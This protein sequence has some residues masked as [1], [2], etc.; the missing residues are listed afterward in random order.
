MVFDV[1]NKAVV[2]ILPA[3][4]NNSND[5]NDE[6][7]YFQF[8]FSDLNNLY[9]DLH[10]GIRHIYPNL[11]I[12]AITWY[13]TSTRRHYP[14]FDEQSMQYAIMHCRPL[15]IYVYKQNVMLK[16]RQSTMMF[17]AREN[18]SNQSPQIN[19][20]DVSMLNQMK[21]FSLQFSPVNQPPQQ[22]HQLPPLPI[23]STF[24]NPNNTRTVSWSEN[25]KSEYPMQIEKTNPRDTDKLSSPL[26][27]YHRISYQMPANVEGNYG[28]VHI[29]EPNRFNSSLN[30]LPFSNNQT[31][32]HFGSKCD[33]CQKAI[34]GIR[35]KCKEC[36][37]YDL[38]EKCKGDGRHSYHQMISIPPP[39]SQGNLYPLT[40]AKQ[41]VS[42]DELPQ[43]QSKNVYK[44]NQTFTPD[45]SVEP[46]SESQKK[47]GWHALRKHT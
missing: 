1:P 34:Y 16:N 28:E 39:N 22:R 10:V 25:S 43:G 42:N 4:S 30:E 11:P 46:V 17:T 36:E 44:A 7:K 41:W 23:S 21:Q 13:N 8:K 12:E 47:G 18:T 15:Y 3:N 38:C 24:F 31:D 35:Y 19:R 14:I 9:N 26:S 33:G 45:N 27:S 32:L 5:P 6:P 20:T 2:V 40:H 29:K 37:D